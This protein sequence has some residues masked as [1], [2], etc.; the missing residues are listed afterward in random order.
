[1]SISSSMSISSTSSSSSDIDDEKNILPQS[2][3]DSDEDSLDF[4]D[5]RCFDI[6]QP[7]NEPQTNKEN[8]YSN[9]F[10]DNNEQQ[11]NEQID[12]DDVMD[13]ESDMDCI[14]P[15]VDNMGQESDTDSQSNMTN[16]ISMSHIDELENDSM[17]IDDD[18]HNHHDNVNQNRIF[19]PSSLQTI[20]EH[21][22]SNNNND[23]IDDIEI[24][25]DINDYDQYIEDNNQYIQE[26]EDDIEHED[27]EKD[28]ILLDNDTVTINEV[29]YQ[30]SNPNTQRLYNQQ[31]S[32]ILTQVDFNNNNEENMTMDIDNIISDNSELQLQENIDPNEGYQPLQKQIL[33]SI[34]DGSTVERKALL[35]IFKVDINKDNNPDLILWRCLEH[36]V[37]DLFAGISDCFKTIRKQNKYKLVRYS[38][39]GIG[40]IQCIIKLFGQLSKYEYNRRVSMQAYLTEFQ[41]DYID[42]KL[43]Q[44]F[45][46][47]PKTREKN[48]MLLIKE[49]IYSLYVIKEYVKEYHQILKAVIFN[50]VKDIVL[51]KNVL[52]EM[53]IFNIFQ[54]VLFKHASEQINQKTTMQTAGWWY[55]NILTS[56]IS[57]NYWCD[58]SLLSNLWI[59]TCRDITY[60]INNNLHWDT[61]CRN[62]L[63]QKFIQY[64]WI[65]AITASYLPIDDQTIK[66]L[67]Y[68]LKKRHN[69]FFSSIVVENDI[70]LM[71]KY[72]IE[73]YGVDIVMKL[74]LLSAKMIANSIEYIV[75]RSRN[76][77]DILLKNQDFLDLADKVPSS[78]DMNEGNHAGI[79]W[80]K[81]SKRAAKFETARNENIWY[82]NKTLSR[83]QNVKYEYRHLYEEIIKYVFA[84]STWSQ[85]KQIKK[86]KQAIST[87]LYQHEQNLIATKQKLIEKQKRKE[88]QILSQSQK[89]NT[90]EQFLFDLQQ[91]R[92]YGEKRKLLISTIKRL[93]LEYKDD[94]KYQHIPTSRRRRDYKTQQIPNYSLQ[95]SIIEILRWEASQ[96]QNESDLASTSDANQQQI[97]VCDELSGFDQES[98]LSSI[99]FGKLSINN[100]GSSGI[101]CFCGFGYYGS[102]MIY[103]EQCLVWYHSRCMN[104]SR[105][106]LSELGSDSDPWRC[107]RCETICNA[108]DNVQYTNGRM[109]DQLDTASIR[110]LD[111]NTNCSRNKR[112]RRRIPKNRKQSQ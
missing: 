56:L 9:P 26:N 60:P 19:Q 57:W 108:K 21:T 67:K 90:E 111:I 59:Y 86:N 31:L 106:E 40:A 79:K 28:V 71:E 109:D 85:Y 5:M 69:V 74:Y 107:P 45:A 89:Y 70:L 77:L 7:S 51:C 80:I 52:L 83:M 55:M 91:K 78:N 97:S 48:I 72:L 94:D 103:C 43:F 23:N 6:E 76:K 110:T 1:M 8:E 93:N 68:Y 44:K 49:A 34:T 25:K 2:L 11:S 42:S 63:Q 99:D 75:K 17:S 12:N 37:N 15:F 33:H 18:N 36:G 100:Y 81:D 96:I 54:S 104:I 58:L 41:S 16:T 101:M 20:I 105:Y 73:T 14:Y 46:S 84:N 61:E 50:E 65:L 47:Y 64:S 87:L 4:W 38:K 82:R 27:E 66:I 39:G 32:P 102:D 3:H 95:Q 35:E 22:D 30:M 112:K 10:L 53:I 13:E 62:D 92:N 88:E 29:G 24:D 98:E